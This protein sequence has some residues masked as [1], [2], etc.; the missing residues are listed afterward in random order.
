MASGCGPQAPAHVEIQ[1]DHSL[2]AGAVFVAMVI[3]PYFLAK[4]TSGHF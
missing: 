3:A 2:V 1:M 4:I